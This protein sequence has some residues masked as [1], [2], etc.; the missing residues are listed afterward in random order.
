MNLNF[1]DKTIL[2]TAGSKG[3]GLALADKFLNLQANVCI[4]S[5]NTVCCMCCLAITYELILILILIM[6]PT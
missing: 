6:L 1:K 5:R 3:I 2:I 4:C